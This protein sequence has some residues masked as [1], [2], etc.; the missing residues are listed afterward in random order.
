MTIP[1]QTQLPDKL[2]AQAQ[3]LVKAGW[4]EDL[5]DLLTDALSRYLESHSL[6]LADK[7]AEEDVQWGLHGTN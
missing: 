4:A 5:D 2:I 1:I 3:E 6:A 7:F